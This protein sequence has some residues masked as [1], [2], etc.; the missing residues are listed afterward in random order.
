MSL[1]VLKESQNCFIIKRMKA[2][3][4]KCYLNLRSKAYKTAQQK[5]L[6]LMINSNFSIENHINLCD[7]NILGA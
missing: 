2:N 6:G 1:T 4:P 7:W 3:A 5:L